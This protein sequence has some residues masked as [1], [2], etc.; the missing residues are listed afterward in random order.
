MICVFFL[1]TGSVIPVYAAADKTLEYDYYF[2]ASDP[3][4]LHYEVDEEI[5]VKGKHYRL[6]D[7]TYDIYKEP[8]VIEKSFKSK[9]KTADEYL[10]DSVQGVDLKL[11]PQEEIKWKDNEIKH[12]E[13]YASEFDVPNEIE[14]EGKTLA[15]KSMDTRS[16]TENISTVAYFY[17]DTLDTTEYVFNGKTVTVDGYEP[18]WSGWQ[19]DYADYLGYSNSNIYA[20][21]GTSW[22]GPAREM[23]SGGYVRTA[24]VYGTKQVSRVVATFG[25]ADEDARY[26]ATVKYKSN[27]V[28]HAKAVYEKYITTRQKIFYAAAG[29]GVLALL[30]SL[31]L[32]I[33]AKRRR[34]EE[35]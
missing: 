32:F 14:Y 27:Y 25:L 18:K 7:I 13:E 15:L 30:T 35:S 2:E 23:Q 24:G 28:A 21:T 1:L 16:G 5:E 34:G 19:Y 4:S 29:I 8:I 3:N 33:L 11:Y 12:T 17:S 20:I 10:E 22:Q 6:K 9:D 31:V 26:T